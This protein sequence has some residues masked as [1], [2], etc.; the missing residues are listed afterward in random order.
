METY[1]LTLVREL[2]AAEDALVKACN[3]GRGN[4]AAIARQ[5]KALAKLLA[6]IFD[7]KPTD[8]ELDAC[9]PEYSD[10]SIQSDN[11]KA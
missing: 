10:F 11:S 7:R 4:K 6:L 2:L 9:D 1:I 5:R 3:E 8:D